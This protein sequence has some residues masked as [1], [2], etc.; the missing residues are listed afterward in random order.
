M[1]GQADSELLV[2]W[3][4][5]EKGPIGIRD[6]QRKVG[7]GSPSTAIYHLERLKS[8]G[9]I[10]KDAD[11][12]YRAIKQT[13]TGILRFY[14]LFAGRLLPKSLIYAI[15]LLVAE[16]ILLGL[17]DFK[18]EIALSL[19][20]AFI[21]TLLFWYEAFDLLKFKREL[22]RKRSKFRTEHSKV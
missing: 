11:G 5:L 3:I 17:S 22:F 21:A 4:V 9:L 7:F 15:V 12:K 19:I 16:L 20:P 2:Y 1:R 13:R 14:I 8:E 10:H 18:F 6:I